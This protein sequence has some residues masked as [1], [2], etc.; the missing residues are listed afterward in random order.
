MSQANKNGQ[1]YVHDMDTYA[2]GSHQCLTVPY[3]EILRHGRL[4]RVE[5]PL[6]LSRYTVHDGELSLKVIS[7]FAPAAGAPFYYGVNAQ[8]REYLIKEVEQAKAVM[9]TESVVN[10]ILD[11]QP[12]IFD[13]KTLIIATESEDV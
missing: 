7:A 9:L 10:W 3:T 4:T 2:A 5:G 6:D 13:G 8:G 1:V 11:R 12:T